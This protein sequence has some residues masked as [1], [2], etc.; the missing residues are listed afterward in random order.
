MYWKVN[1]VSA[2]LYI[3]KKKETKK[4]LSEVIFCSKFAE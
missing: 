2:R 4:N 3:T 1:A